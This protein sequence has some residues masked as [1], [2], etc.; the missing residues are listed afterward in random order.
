MEIQERFLNGENQP[1]S[2]SLGWSVQTGLLRQR[3]QSPKVHTER[4]VVVTGS[5]NG[6]GL[7][8][9]QGIAC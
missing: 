5:L 1:D 7:G 2:F 6:A 4:A 3:E 8:C 9:V